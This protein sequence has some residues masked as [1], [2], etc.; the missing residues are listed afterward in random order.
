MFIHGWVGQGGILADMNLEI[1]FSEMPNFD[2][3]TLMVRRADSAS[4]HF[5]LKIKA[6]KNFDVS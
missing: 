6:S 4:Q 1:G 3:L 2:I 5:Q